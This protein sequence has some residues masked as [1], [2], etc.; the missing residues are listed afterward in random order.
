M[1]IFDLYNPPRLNK[2]QKNEK[3]LEK[4]H[5][6]YNPPRLNKNGIIIFPSFHVVSLYNPPRLNKNVKR[7][8]RKKLKQ[9][10]TI[11]QG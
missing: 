10:F 9:H 5:Q 7:Q 11:L 8:F 1:F 4:P 3:N 6:L 2:N